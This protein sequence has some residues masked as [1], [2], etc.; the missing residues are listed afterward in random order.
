V[1]GFGHGS[2]ERHRDEDDPAMEARGGGA[3]SEAGVG[4]QSACSRASVGEDS[5]TNRGVESGGVS[6][7]TGG[8]I[9]GSLAPA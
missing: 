4:E 8:M 1:R 9:Q 2:E 3:T 6:L 5:T 7:V